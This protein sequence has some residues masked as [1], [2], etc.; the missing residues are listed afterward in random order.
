MSKEIEDILQNE[1]YIEPE[2]VRYFRGEDTPSLQ[3]L[4]DMTYNLVTK[5]QAPY[6]DF[7][8]FEDIVH[9]LNDMQPDVENMQGSTP[10]QIW[11][12][13]LEMKKMLGKDPELS[14]EVKTYIKFIYKDSGCLFLPS[15]GF[16]ETENPL[17]GKVQERVE[18]G[19]VIEDSSPL[20]NQAIKYLR[21]LE[22]KNQKDNK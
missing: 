12:A 3:V 14:H 19:S 7:Y 4:K 16:S 18:A 13:L 17:L 5:T 15:I 8:V 9:V 21:I 22:Y 1:D 10:E 11:Y 6:V 20:D 2:T